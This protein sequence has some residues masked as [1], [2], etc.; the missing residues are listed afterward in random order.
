M[1]VVRVSSS[2]GLVGFAN[3]DQHL[4]AKGLCDKSMRLPFLCRS[5]QHFAKATRSVDQVAYCNASF[6]HDKAKAIF[7]NEIL[8]VLSM[9]QNECFAFPS[10]IRHALY[11]L[12]EG[13]DLPKDKI[14]RQLR[15]GAV[16]FYPPT[17]LVWTIALV[18][19]WRLYLRRRKGGKVGV[20]SVNAGA[21]AGNFILSAL[22]QAAGGRKG[23]HDR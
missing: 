3:P 20:G 4:R 12:P 21:E 22:Q 2:G 11:R 18:L 14:E 7:C 9:E 19:G 15:R 5:I 10:L 1:E 16:D 17:F 23:R 13:L 8:A 6:Q